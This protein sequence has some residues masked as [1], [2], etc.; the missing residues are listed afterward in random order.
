MQVVTG[1]TGVPWQ[2]GGFSIEDTNELISNKLEFSGPL[3][4]YELLQE[5]FCAMHFGVK[6]FTEA[7]QINV[8]ASRENHGKSC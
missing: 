3:S 1:W 4:K 6:Y 5:R 2:F 8:K 7:S